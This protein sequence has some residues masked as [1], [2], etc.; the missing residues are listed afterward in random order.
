MKN[1]TTPP[2]QV[3]LSHSA[4]DIDLVTAFEN[5]L[6]KALNI[7]SQSIFCSTLEGQGVKKGGDF[8]DEIK[9]KAVEA[10]AVVALLSPTYMESPFC[11]AELGAAW[12]LN[13]NRFPV[14]V[15]PNT[16]EIMQATLLGVVGVKVD[17]EDA[18]TQLLEDIGDALFLPAPKA[19][20]R[21]R[22]IRDFIK[23]WPN[24]KDSIG[25]AKRV[26]ASV[27]IKALADLKM[28]RE[29]WEGT[30]QELKTANEKI[31]ALKKIKDAKKVAEVSKAFDESD[32]ESELDNAISSVSE[33]AVEVGGTRVLRH[34]I[35]E[36]LGKS[37]HPDF[38]DDYI[39]RAIEIDLYDP[40]SKAWDYSSDEMIAL[41]KAMKKVEEVFERNEDA[42]SELKRQGKRNRTDDIRFWE[43][44]V[45]L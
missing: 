2:V 30:E 44:Q 39:E 27:H 12:V 25:K 18:L 31:E 15:P 26:D 21:A 17:Q 5:L 7:T 41:K 3:F 34:M 45:G 42:A 36:I 32:W 43:Q 11:L 1:V 6:C 40:E 19:A 33:I 4:A 13:T 24:L 20:V 28:F 14:I 38:D 8:V 35:L 22:A 37:S 9:G 16:F 29:A 23:A 10:K